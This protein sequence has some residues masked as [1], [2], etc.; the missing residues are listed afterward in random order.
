MR[1]I[2]TVS[3]PLSFFALLFPQFLFFWFSTLRQQLTQI[4]NWAKKD[5]L[6]I[7]LSLFSFFYYSRQPSDSDRFWSLQQYPKHPTMTNMRR[8][9]VMKQRFSHEIFLHNFNVLAQS[10][11]SWHKHIQSTTNNTAEASSLK[12][13]WRRRRRCA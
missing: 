1:F 2:V 5:Y 8:W 13:G 9:V 10:E 7:F 4:V 11:I 12:E 6:S 3:T